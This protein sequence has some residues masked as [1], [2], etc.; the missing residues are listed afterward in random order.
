LRAGCG[1]RLDLPEPRVAL[2]IALRRV[3]SAAIDVSDGL[4]AD[5]GHIA[6]RSAVCALIEYERLPQAPALRGCA[7]RRIADAALLAGGDDYEL[8][9]TAPA[10]ARARVQAVGR[11]LGIP[12]ERIGRIEAG[13]AG[14]V[15]VTRGGRLLA[16]GRRGFDHF[17]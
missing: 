12:V 2:G 8:C 15:A 13:R 16:P 7:S 4:V 17:G 11:R 14:S 9:F 10:R 1:R 3:A 5:L 6:E